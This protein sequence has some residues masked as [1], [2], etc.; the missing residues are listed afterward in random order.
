MADFYAND[1]MNDIFVQL[2]LNNNL[3]LQSIETMMQT[4]Y[5]LKMSEVKRNLANNNNTP[6][7]YL[8]SEN[9]NYDDSL[10]NLYPYEV[11]L[12]NQIS[13]NKF[14]ELYNRVFELITT[15]VGDRDFD[16]ENFMKNK[17]EKLMAVE[18]GSSLRK[19]MEE[20]L[21]D[22]RKEIDYWRGVIIYLKNSKRNLI[23]LTYG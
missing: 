23:L 14:Y 1:V 16:W 2:A 7:K 21:Y 20:I 11:L 10:F 19:K 3:S 9:L 15:K 4:K 13:A 17:I 12:N 6:I 22:D 18:K 8:I 5:L